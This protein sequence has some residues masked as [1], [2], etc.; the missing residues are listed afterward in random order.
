[1][2]TNLE[3]TY[4]YTATDDFTNPQKPRFAYSLPLHHETF[5]AD[6]S[7]LPEFEK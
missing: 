3:I 2:S 6:C 4:N 7:D 5:V 1:M